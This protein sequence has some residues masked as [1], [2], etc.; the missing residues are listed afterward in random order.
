[1]L[2]QSLGRFVMKNESNT[3]RGLAFSISFRWSDSLSIWQTNANTSCPHVMVYC[4]NSIPTGCCHVGLIYGL[5]LPMA[6]R[7]RVKLFL[8]IIWLYRSF[9]LYS[10]VVKPKLWQLKCIFCTAQK[11][12]HIL[13]LFTCIENWMNPRRFLI[14][15]KKLVK[16]QLCAPTCRQKNWVLWPNRT[17]KK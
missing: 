17:E 8:K 4:L 3:L 9:H 12:E 14:T 2:L 6:G 13:Y 5:I 16:S 7:N 1:M 10:T 11:Y 15:G